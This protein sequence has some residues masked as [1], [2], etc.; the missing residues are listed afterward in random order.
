MRN[1]AKLGCLLL[2]Q[3]ILAVVSPTSFPQTLIQTKPVK[4]IRENTP[5]V[6]ALV[7]ARIVPAPGRQIEKGTIVLRD[8]TIEAVGD[9]IELPPDARIWDCEGMWIY[10]GFLESY[11]QLGLPK[12][13]S[14]QGSGTA[15][16]SVHPKGAE[17]WNPHVHPQ[18]NAMDIYEPSAADATKLRALGFTAVLVTPDKGVFCGSSAMISLKDGSSNDQLIEQNVAQ[19]ILLK[20]PGG[21]YP[22]SQ[23]GVIALIRQ[24]FLDA[25]WYQKAH[26]AYA[27]SPAGQTRPES[28]AALEALANASRQKRP[29]L[30]RVEDDLNCLR[31]LKLAK[32]FAL[33]AW[34]LG[35]GHEYRQIRALKN[36]G[37]PFIIP[38]SFPKAPSVESPEEAL[39]VSLLELTHWD[40]APENPKR[41]HEAGI[42]FAFT[43]ARL[44]KPADFHKQVRKAVKR[45]LPQDVALAALTTIPAK[46]I[47]VDDR[48][49]TIDAGKLGHLVVTD[50]GLFKEDTKIFDV[51]VDGHRYEIK[52]K[53]EAD[54]RGQWQMALDF[55]DKSQKV[56]LT[57]KG[58]V[59]KLKGF[60]SPDGT[61]VTLK[62]VDVDSKRVLITFKGDKLG[63]AGLVRASGTVERKRMSGRGELPNGRMF[64][65]TA[66]LLKPPKSEEKKSR[67]DDKKAT[68][69]AA[70][71]FPLGAYAYLQI[72]KQPE[73][74]L[75]RG[76]TIWTCGPRGKLENADMIVARGK[77]AQVGRDL[78]TPPGAVVIQAKG[79]HVTPGLI[80]AHSHTGVD[81]GVNE[82][83]QAVSS[84][85][86]VEDVINNNEIAFYRQLAGGLTAANLLHGSAIPIGGQNAVVKL[87]WGFSPDEFVIRDA[88]PG[89]K[90]ALGENVR[91]GNAPSRK[92]RMGVEQI[93]R[94]RFKA[95]LDYEKEWKTYNAK[96]QKE[97]VIPPRRD[98][99]LE[100]LVEVL[101]HKRDVLAHAYR[102]DEM[103][104]LIRVADEFGFT[105]GAFQHGQEGYKIADVIAYHNGGGVSTFSDWWAYKFEVY[106]AIPHSGALMHNAGVLVTF[107]SDSSE[108]ARRLN[109]E[110]AKA[111]KYGGVP[112][113]EALKFV[114]LNAAKQLGI[115]HRVGSLEVKKDADFTIWSGNPLSTYSRCEQTWI[116]GRKHFDIEEDRKMREQVLAERARLIQKALGAAEREKK[117]KEASEE[118]K[119]ES[120]QSL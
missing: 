36:A 111:V 112:E 56:Q 44:K 34:I 33:K 120:R 115:D 100:T 96:K 41:L 7:N 29:V 102:Q 54:P 118:K 26:D 59:E 47:G 60:L 64:K 103:L 19:N 68:E 83:G 65:W 28:N 42:S 106:D 49:G 92:S 55:P 51:W 30:F 73:Y 37:V 72:P 22:V 14:K 107:N 50:G 61:T 86:R 97:G 25:D 76:A 5:R 40:M 10:P 2:V 35:S 94:D 91:R 95:A 99:E 67:A 74:V 70:P 79:K 108:L 16:Q 18:V 21:G 89:V 114:T 119:P 8:G 11:S 78:G 63:Y 32:E 52:K 85:V 81:Q 105:L 90:F 58:S 53:P 113:E 15:P 20:R 109:L 12:E 31:A 6:H 1:C 110:A 77:I 117:E 24:T 98:L 71:A 101:N 57:L 48:L 3:L 88:A 13:S 38:V 75:V 80:D 27:L 23:M 69:S 116:E 9:N 82:S 93:I 17:H 43:T 4:G 104:M 39:D 66:G 62:K 45:G 84:E 46:M 87:R